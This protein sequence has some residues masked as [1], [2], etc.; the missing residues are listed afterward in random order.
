VSRV[1]QQHGV[2][3]LHVT[4]ELDLATTP[5]LRAAVA[6]ALTSRPQTLALDLSGCPFAGVDAVNALV[7]LTTEAQR[8]G[9]TLLL[10][11]PRPILRRAIDL[12]GPRDLLRLAPVPHP[13]RASRAPR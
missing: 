1:G 8:Q 7:D 11:G 13:R 12:V 2:T 10:V 4:E 3:T 5:A 6:D 9:T